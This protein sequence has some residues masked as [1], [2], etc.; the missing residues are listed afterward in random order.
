MVIPPTWAMTIATRI[1][2]SEMRRKHFQ[3]VSLDAFSNE[4]AMRIE[5]A[6]DESFKPAELA[7]LGEEL[8]L[9]RIPDEHHR[10]G[11][12]VF[13]A[14]LLEKMD[15]RVPP[16]ELDRIGKLRQLGQLREFW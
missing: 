13:R 10:R 9:A 14:A 5:V 15:D 1:A 4:D 16:D 11:L 6:V 7:V 2:I 3:D 8:H 12:T